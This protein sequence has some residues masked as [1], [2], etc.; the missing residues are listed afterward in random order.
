MGAS[1]QYAAVVGASL[2]PDHRF[3]DNGNVFNREDNDMFD[4]IALGELLI[5]FTPYVP[6]GTVLPYLSKN[7][8]RSEM[9]FGGSVP[10]GSKTAFIVGKICTAIYSKIPWRNAESIPPA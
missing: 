9:Y 10:P 4:V 2:Y 5:D 3:L 8:G 6:A 1:D 7:P